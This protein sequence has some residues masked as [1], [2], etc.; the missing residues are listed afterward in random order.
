MV[1]FH[2]ITTKIKRKTKK[3]IGR[4]GKRGTYSGRGVKG[5]KSRAGRRIRPALRD[6]VKR[7]PK[8]RGYQFKSIAGR[9]ATLT[10]AVIDKFF[11]SGEIVSPE[12]VLAKGI[13]NKKQIRKGIKIVATGRLDKSLRFQAVSFSAKARELVSKAN[14]N[15]NKEKPKKTKDKQVKNKRGR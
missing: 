9:P 3:R 1:Q 12:T 5:Q 2:Q 14:K 11:K 7:M 15:T 4:G 13:F 10:L 6:A 8:L